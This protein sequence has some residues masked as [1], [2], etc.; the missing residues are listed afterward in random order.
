MPG[1]G[2][3]RLSRRHSNESLAGE[4]AEMLP[5]AIDDKTAAD[6]ATA[7][8]RAGSRRRKRPEV[9]VPWTPLGLTY[10]GG[11]RRRI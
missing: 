11:G 9:C 6:A 5:D 8:K 4:D 1:P 10:A 7:G 2:A 3:R